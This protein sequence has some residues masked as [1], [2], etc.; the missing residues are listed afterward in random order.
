MPI[1]RLNPGRT[2]EV[3]CQQFGNEW[4]RGT[5]FTDY[6]FRRRNP[7]LPQNVIGNQSAIDDYYED[8]ISYHLNSASPPIRV[9]IPATMPGASNQIDPACPINHPGTT[10]APLSQP[11]ALNDTPIL[12]GMTKQLPKGMQ[13]AGHAKSKPPEPKV[14]KH[15]LL[16][17][18]K[19]LGC[20]S[21]PCGSFVHVNLR[22]VY[23]FEVFWLQF[24][25]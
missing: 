14:K 18:K 6:D 25:R 5:T 1:N 22:W 15:Y 21:T 19:C 13:E 10:F 9:T 16:R 7:S 11:N 4:P 24:F 12:H 20:H 8:L 2:F 23:I 17:I 3:I